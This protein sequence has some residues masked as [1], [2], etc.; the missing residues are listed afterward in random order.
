MYLL[1]KIG[2]DTAEND[3]LKAADS[4]AWENT[5]LVLSRLLKA[6]LEDAW[7]PAPARTALKRKSGKTDEKNGVVFAK[8]ANLSA[9]ALAT[10]AKLQNLSTF[11]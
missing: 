3:P 4:A 1:A 11:G 9:K 10:F 7:I 6:D 5:E 2:V 8:I